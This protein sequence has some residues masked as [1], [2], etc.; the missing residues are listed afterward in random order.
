METRY[1]ITPLRA[2]SGSKV[3]NS[4]HVRDKDVYERRWNEDDVYRLCHPTIFKRNN[5]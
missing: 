5:T 2:S 4:I 1:G 3:N